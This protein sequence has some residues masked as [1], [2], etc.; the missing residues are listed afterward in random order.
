MKNKWKEYLA[1]RKEL[2]SETYK[3]KQKKVKAVVKGNEEKEMTESYRDKQ[4]LFYSL[5]KQQE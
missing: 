5:L 4:R 1:T 3:D 2:D